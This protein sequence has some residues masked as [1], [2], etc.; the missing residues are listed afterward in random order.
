MMQVDVDVFFRMQLTA[1]PSP[2][3]G[4]PGQPWVWG[5][6]PLAIPI[7]LH[8]WSRQQNRWSSL[9]ILTWAQGTSGVTGSILHQ[10]AQK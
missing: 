5:W 7:A 6:L 4:L 10:P 2:A 9:G 1:Q 8:K 3:L